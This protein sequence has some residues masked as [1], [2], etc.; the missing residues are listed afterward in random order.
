[1]LSGGSGNITSVLSVE[2]DAVSLISLAIRRLPQHRCELLDRALRF[3]R[4]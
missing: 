2:P 3:G 1:V 4:W